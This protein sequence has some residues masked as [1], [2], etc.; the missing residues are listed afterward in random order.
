VAAKDREETERAANRASAAAAQAKAAHKAAQVV[1]AET[2][3]IVRDYERPRPASVC[4]LR[5]LLLRDTDS[6]RCKTPSDFTMGKDL[7]EAL[8]YLCDDIGDDQDNR[9]DAESIA[10]LDAT[11]EPSLLA[12]LRNLVPLARLT[13][14]KKALRKVDAE[15]EKIQYLHG[16]HY[17]GDMNFFRPGAVP[18]VD[19]MHAFFS[20]HGYDRQGA[21]QSY[22]GFQETLP[23]GPRG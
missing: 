6:V 13:A 19:A 9:F 16:Q 12:K 7:I 22:L 3:R 1:H 20:P 8:K 11:F 18:I 2:E 14:I 15:R 4:E 23:L 17:L 10:A 5:D 21:P